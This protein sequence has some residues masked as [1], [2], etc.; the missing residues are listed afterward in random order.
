MLQCQSAIHLFG[1]QEGVPLGHGPAWVGQHVCPVS[2]LVTCGIT[3]QEDLPN[4]II[5]ADF[6][7][8]PHRNHQLDPLQDKQ[9]DRGEHR[10]SSLELMA[11]DTVGDL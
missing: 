6:V 9:G 8:I 10:E 5:P 7:M 3:T 11:L 2:Q 1:G 4:G